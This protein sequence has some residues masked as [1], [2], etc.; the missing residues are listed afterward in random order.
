MCTYCSTLELSWCEQFGDSKKKKNWVNLKT[1]AFELVA[2]TTVKW[3]ISR[4]RKDENSGEMNKNEK[5]S[6]KAYKATDFD[7]L[8]L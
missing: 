3:I 8:N 5:R 6:Y 7:H 1:S 4:R 2:Q